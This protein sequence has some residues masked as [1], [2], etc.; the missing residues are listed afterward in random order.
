MVLDI[1]SF[2]LI[3]AVCSFAF[4]L[5][6]LLIRKTYPQNLGR[7]LLYCGVASLCLGAGWAFL[8]EGGVIGRVP[9]SC[10]QPGT[11]HV[12][13]E[14]AVPRRVRNQ[15]ANVLN[16]WVVGPPLGVFAVCTWFSFVDRTVGTGDSLHPDSN[17]SDD[18]AG[19]LSFSEGRGAKA[20]CPTLRSQG[21][22]RCL[23]P[24]R[25]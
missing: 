11:A 16:A 18:S 12:V 14:P 17:I 5:L 7:M 25:R 24:S 21:T 2:W 1:R 3:G 15:A 20:V 23:L 9:V 8:F 10:S 13:P 19:G 4:G 22:T 6:L